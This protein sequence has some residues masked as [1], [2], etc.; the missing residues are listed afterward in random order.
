MKYER[1]REFMPEVG[2]E[3]HIVQQRFALHTLYVQTSQGRQLRD[4][5]LQLLASFVVLI[6]IVPVIPLALPPKIC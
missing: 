4:G 1:V 5:L 3:A 6:C 2:Q